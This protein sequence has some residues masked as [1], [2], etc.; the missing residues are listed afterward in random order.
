MILVIIQVARSPQDPAQ[1]FR[2]HGDVLV[3][4]CTG[5]FWLG[6]VSGVLVLWATVWAFELGP[7]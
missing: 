1:A 5:A 6:F 7:S 3:F 2:S 4:I